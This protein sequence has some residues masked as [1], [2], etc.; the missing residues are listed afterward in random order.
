[1]SVTIVRN[2]ATGQVLRYTCP[3]R[4]AVVAAYAQEHKDF[5]TWQYA[6]RY[7][8]R[9]EEGQYTYLLGNWGSFK[10]QAIEWRERGEPNP[11]ESR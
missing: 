3:P 10:D 5:N 11:K 1:M 9:V 2:L 8:S 7:D 4:Q 6:E